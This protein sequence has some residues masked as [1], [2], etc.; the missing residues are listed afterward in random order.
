MPDPTI[1]QYAPDSVSPPGESLLDTL[2]FLGMSQAELA[3]R[4]GLAQKTVNQ[5]INGKAPISEGTAIALERVLGTP[6]H[7]WLSREA[8]YRES[9]ARQQE[10]Q[11]KKTHAS[12]ARQFPYK[13][14]A[15]LGWVGATSKAEEKAISLLRFFGVNDQDCWRSLWEESQVAFRKTSR[16]NKKLEVISCWL[17]QGEVEAQKLNVPEF[18]ET[19]FRDVVESLR[20]LTL[21]ANDPAGF[22]NE[23]H[24]RCAEVGVR[25]LVVREL[26]S[27]GVYGV[28]RWFGG[29]PMIQQSMLL[30]SHD[31]FW[32]TFFHEAKHVL[33]KVKKHI[34]LEGDKL[35]EEDQKREEEANRFA[36]SL[37]IPDD[38][39]SEFVECGRFTV[40]AITTFAQKIKTHPGIVVGRLQREG[41][42]E[43]SDPAG[44]LKARYKWTA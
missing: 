41:H 40:R 31:H 7:F 16:P 37:L 34:F 22:I 28:T 15:D 3:D 23:V 33:Q 4:T 6:A 29:S 27:L 21:K 36:G 19:G 30:K 32:F 12:W 35:T 8:K 9:I 13:A 14:M 38:P 26:P 11:L 44:R 17:R 25:F 39:Y 18:D 20:P 43:Y 2:E 5:I 42:I 24:G 10:E 1:S